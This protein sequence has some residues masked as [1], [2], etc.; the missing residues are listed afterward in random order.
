MQGAVRVDEERRGCVFSSEGCKVRRQC[1]QYV[2]GG[3]NA[4]G[5]ETAQL[6]RDDA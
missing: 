5:A 4:R 6:R 2:N 1:A 3:Y